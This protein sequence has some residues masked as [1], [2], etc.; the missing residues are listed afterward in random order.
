MTEHVE[1]EHEHEHEATVQSSVPAETVA[2]PVSVLAELLALF[3]N[4]PAI[5]AD[6]EKLLHDFGH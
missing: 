3:K 6:L 4:F 1:H 5:L 2:V